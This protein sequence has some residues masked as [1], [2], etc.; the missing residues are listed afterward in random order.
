MIVNAALFSLQVYT[1]IL[2]VS[3]MTVGIIIVIINIV[4]I[5]VILVAVDVWNTIN[6]T[7]VSKT[8]RAVAISTK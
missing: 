5:V 4:F 2:V 3:V 6:Y 7:Y 1:I 8:G